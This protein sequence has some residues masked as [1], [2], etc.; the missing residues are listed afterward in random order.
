ML[1]R[2]MLACQY[3]F[4]REVTVKPEFQLE[5]GQLLFLG[6]NKSMIIGVLGNFGSPI[7]I[8]YLNQT[9]LTQ[10]LILRTMLTKKE[11]LLVHPWV[12]QRYRSHRDKVESA[13]P[14]IDFRTP[15]TRPHVTLKRKKRQKEL[16]RKK[17]IEQENVRL[18][19]KLG[20]IMTRT[21]RVDNFWKQPRPK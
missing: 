19:Q 2:N 14:A 11:K 7:G 6:I 15:P 1:E 20:I 21:L 18:L 13:G 8:V 17:D 4:T 16:E 9:T 12:L 3:K 10:S 5:C